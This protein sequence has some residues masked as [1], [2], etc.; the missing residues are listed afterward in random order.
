MVYGVSGRNLGRGAQF[1]IYTRDFEKLDVVRNDEIAQE[2]SLPKPL[3]Y[4]RML[5]IAENIGRHFPHVRVD[6]YNVAGRIYFGELTFY[7]GSGYMTF[8]PDSYDKDLG[9]KFD[10]SE[11]K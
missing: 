9:N 8:T 5:E 2:Q 6:L 7:D 3:N 4:E 11:F 1:G 10:I